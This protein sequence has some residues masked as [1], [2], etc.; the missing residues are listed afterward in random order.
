MPH[1]YLSDDEGVDEVHP[2]EA[3][4]KAA[5][6]MPEPPT[7]RKTERRKFVPKEPVM[8]GPFLFADQQLPPLLQASPVQFIGEIWRTSPFSNYDG[9][10]ASLEASHRAKTASSTADVPVKTPVVFPESLV[11]SLVKVQP[12]QMRHV[13]HRVLVP[14]STRLLLRM[15]MPASTS[16]TMNSSSSTHP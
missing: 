5:M 15:S 12:A 8:L 6:A 11:P 2:G 7:K 9:V 3:E 13:P 10:F 16:S 4:E 1:G 14:N